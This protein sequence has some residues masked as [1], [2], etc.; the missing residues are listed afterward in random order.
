MIEVA[1]YLSLGG[2]YVQNLPMEAEAEVNG[3]IVLEQRAEVEIDSPFLEFG[4]GY[5]HNDWHVEINR[6]GVL[7]NSDESITTFR[8]YKRI[9]F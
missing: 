3:A 4:A 9:Y 5:E 1:F 7:D 8:I 6:F 2:G